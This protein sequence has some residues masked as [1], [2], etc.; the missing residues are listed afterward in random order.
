M[1]QALPSPILYYVRALYD[2]IPDGDTEIEI[3][4]GDIVAVTS[5][6]EDWSR[7]TTSDGRSG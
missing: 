3:H 4:P 6:T 7:G 2:F 5:F 1:A